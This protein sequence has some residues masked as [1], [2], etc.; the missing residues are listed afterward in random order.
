MTR[1]ARSLFVFG[2]Y[3]LLLG[4]TLVVAP[5]PLLRLFGL[6]ATGEVW[7]RVAGVL[8]AILGAYDLQAARYRLIPLFRTTIVAR[9]AVLVLFIVFTSAGLVNPILVLFGV[10]DFLGAVWT[11]LALRADRAAAVGAAVPAAGSSAA[12][13]E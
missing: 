8:V 12:R 7:I 2:T 4:V 11:W 10:I 3:L 1:A 13:A 6:P 5:N 9:T